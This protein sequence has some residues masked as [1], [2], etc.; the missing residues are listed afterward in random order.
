[1][2]FTAEQISY[3]GKSAI[4]FIVRKKPED[5][6]N[7][8]RPFLTWLR[9]NQKSFPGAKQYI[10]EK[11][12]IKNDSNFQWFGPDGL[13]T[14]NRKRTLAEANFEWRSAHDGFGLTEEELLQNYISVTDDP[15]NTPT[16]SEKHQ[17]INLMTENTETLFLGFNEMFDYDLH[18]DG[19][20]STDSL[21]GLD[22]IISTT[23]TSGIVGGINRATAGNE[24]WRNHVSLSIAATSGVLT[25][26]M[27]QV[28]RA[29]T[30]VGGFAPNY[31]MVGSKF[32]DAYRTDAQS[33]INRQIESSGNQ[34]GG[35]SMDASVSRLYFKNVELIWSPVFDDLQTNLSPG[36]AWD[37]RCYFLNSR[38]LKLRPAKG[39]DMVVRRPPRAYDRYT[40]YWGL[41][42]RG[43]LTTNRP[44]SMA[45]L[46]IV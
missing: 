15:T 17:F 29:C 40:H 3:A 36:T 30:R 26:T 35:V 10:N 39:Q 7:T 6:Y 46:S 11:L 42:W 22:A 28:W 1:M 8:E 16:T 33:I 37:K 34:R 44:G 27:E 38:F 32:L 2:P 5:L 18:L 45:V 9:A 14:Y 12:R 24:Y 13:V 19:T 23:P 41:T 31:I 43:G 20:A 25:K 21:V 4:D